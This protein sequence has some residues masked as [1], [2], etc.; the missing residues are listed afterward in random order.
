MGVFSNITINTS[1]EWTA[2]LINFVVFIIPLL[3][4]G[5]AARRLNFIHGAIVAMAWYCMIG[6]VY[7]V[8]KAYDAAWLQDLQ[9]GMDKYCSFAYAVPVAVVER[10]FDAKPITEINIF[11]GDGAKYWSFALC[12]AIPIV[13]WLVSRLISG[14]VRNRRGY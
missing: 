3:F 14:A 8:T 12:F 4:G 10:F 6:G 5:F 1:V 2:V 7:L 11:S 9:E 13:I